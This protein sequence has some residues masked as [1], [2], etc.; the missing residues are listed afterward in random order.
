M[1][2]SERLGGEGV[3]AGVLRRAGAAAT[4]FLADQGSDIEKLI[5]LLGACG[6]DN[7]TTLAESLRQAYFDEIRARLGAAAI[8]DRP[9]L[10]TALFDMHGD[11]K[12]RSEVELLTGVVTTN[13][14]GLL[15][16]ASPS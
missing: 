1:Q 4:P 16:I 14:D 15:Q 11:H 2:D 13:H 10:A 12:F 5:S 3:S 9:E 7:L 6:V 8:L